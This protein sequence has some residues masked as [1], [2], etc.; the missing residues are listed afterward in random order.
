MKQ[1]LTRA[2]PAWGIM[3]LLALVCA[4]CGSKDS[5]TRPVGTPAGGS[6]SPL[7]PQAQAAVQAQEKADAAQHAARAPR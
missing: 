5:E 6:T 7:P 3:T 2:M 1:Y 4:G